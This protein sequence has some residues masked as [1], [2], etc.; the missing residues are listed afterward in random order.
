MSKKAKK[1]LKVLQAENASLKSALAD[2]VYEKARSDALEAEV[3]VL[4]QQAQHWRAMEAELPVLRYNSERYLALEGQLPE[5]QYKAVRC[6]ELQTEV[7][8]LRYK[9]LRYDEL[10]DNVPVWRA[11]ADRYDRIVLRSPVNRILRVLRITRRQ[12]SQMTPGKN[13]ALSPAEL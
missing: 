6:N 4:R 3:T 10:K 7:M 9:A 11:K 5:L 1:A 13:E 2:E 12:P 8:S